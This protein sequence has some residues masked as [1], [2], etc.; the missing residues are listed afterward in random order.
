MIFIYC[1]GVDM[2]LILFDKEKNWLI[3]M[4]QIIA[5]TPYLKKIKSIVYQICVKY[6]KNINLVLIYNVN[7]ERV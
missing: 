6:V 3:A 5:H 2:H 7:F 1:T 4:L